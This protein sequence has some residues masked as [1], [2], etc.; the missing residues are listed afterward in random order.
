MVTS[1]ASILIGSA[2]GTLAMS[3]FAL[4]ILVIAVIIKGSFL[5]ANSSATYP[6][7]FNLL[8]SDTTHLSLLLFYLTPAAIMQDVLVA[9]LDTILGSVMSVTLYVSQ[10]MLACLA[11]SR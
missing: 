5:T 1:V 7:L 11:C 10:A 9:G 8:L 2:V 3:G 4:N 6:L